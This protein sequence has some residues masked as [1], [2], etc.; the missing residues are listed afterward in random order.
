MRPVQISG[1]EEPSEPVICAIDR[2]AHERG[3]MCRSQEAIS[4]KLADDN[5]VVVGYT[6]GWRFRGTGVAAMMVLVRPHPYR[7]YTS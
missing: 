6:K 3:D 7:Y 4:R 5:H 2:A 1:V